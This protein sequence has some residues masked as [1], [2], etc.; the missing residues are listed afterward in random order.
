M[1]NVY[2]YTDKDGWNAI[3]AQ[4]TWS[5]KA[6]RPET[7]DR[8]LGACFTDIELSAE[9]LRTLHKRLRIPKVKRE[10]VF[11]FVGTDGLTWLLGGR[12]RDKRI[13]HSPIDYYVVE[14]RQKYQGKTEAL[15]EG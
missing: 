12:G 11:W 4:T 2:H 5:F 15:M 8:P 14:A 7:P 10:Y 3:R 13:F 6:S 1:T 9:T